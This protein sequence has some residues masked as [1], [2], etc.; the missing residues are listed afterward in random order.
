MNPRH[1]Y[2]QDTIIYIYIYIYIYIHIQYVCM[3]VPIYEYSHTYTY[4]HRYIDTHIHTRTHHKSITLIY[5]NQKLQ[6]N[7]LSSRKHTNTHKKNLKKHKHQSISHLLSQPAFFPVRT[8]N[9]RPPDPTASRLITVRN[10]R[11][12]TMGSCIGTLPNGCRG[13]S[14]EIKPWA[15]CQLVSSAPLNS[16][17][18]EL[19]RSMFGEDASWRASSSMMLI[20]TVS[21]TAPGDCMY[22]CMHVFVCVYVS[23]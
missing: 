21:S 15:A 10:A 23:W 4:I 12:H 11:R 20:W 16:S 19:L 18:M 9:S 2:V 6:A 3:Y 22:V 8:K 13:V 1:A 5:P 14:V 7:S 17:T